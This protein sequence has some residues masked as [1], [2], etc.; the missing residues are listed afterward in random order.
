[1]RCARTEVSARRAAT[2]PA[3][4]RPLLTRISRRAPANAGL[5][6]QIVR[7]RTLTRDGA[8]DWGA[9]T[10]FNSPAISAIALSLLRFGFRLLSLV[11]RQRPADVILRLGKLALLVASGEALVARIGFDQLAVA[12]HRNLRN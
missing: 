12:C 8:P 9:P 10:R 2:R 4:L 7:R 6:L 1:M 11:L 5:G 3:I